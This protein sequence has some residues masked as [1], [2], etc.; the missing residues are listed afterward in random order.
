MKTKCNNEE[1]EFGSSQDKYPDGSASHLFFFSHDVP[2]SQRPDIPMFSSSAPNF[3]LTNLLKGRTPNHMG[4]GSSW[5]SVFLL[6]YTVYLLLAHAPLVFP[7][8]CRRVLV[9][10]TK[11]RLLKTGQQPPHAHRTRSLSTA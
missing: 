6:V 2:L 3:A 10:K 4:L 8:I 7:L 1:S 11:E 9:P 5:N